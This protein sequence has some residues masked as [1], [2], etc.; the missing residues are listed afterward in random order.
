MPSAA[1]IEVYCGK[2][3]PSQFISVT[4]D[5]Y[6]IGYRYSRRDQ[7]FI[8]V[9]KPEGSRKVQEIDV[10]P[11]V[12]ARVLPEVKTKIMQ[13]YTAGCVEVNDLQLIALGFIVKE[14]FSR[15][16]PA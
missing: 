15:Y 9:W 16:V 8:L 6:T 14:V 4:P 5:L 10:L 11:R 2:D 7:R 3:K 1:I 12:L 13:G